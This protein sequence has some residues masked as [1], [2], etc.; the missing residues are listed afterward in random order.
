MRISNNSN[1]SNNSSN[2]GMN[3]PKGVIASEAKQSILPSFRGDAKHRT[4]V[5]NCAPENLEIP[6]SPFGRPGMTVNNSIASSQELLAMTGMD[7]ELS[8]GN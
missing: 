7:S 5:R 2:D 4:M 3:M 6:G 8:Q 1:N